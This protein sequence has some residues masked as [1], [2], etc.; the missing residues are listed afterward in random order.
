MFVKLF[1]LLNLLP[2][3]MLVPD[4]SIL[5]VPDWSIMFAPD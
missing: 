4:L 1:K 3:V 5:F 2:P